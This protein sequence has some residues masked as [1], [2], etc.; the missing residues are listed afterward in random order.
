MKT[1][2]DATMQSLD[3]AISLVGGQVPLAESLGVRQQTVSYWRKAG[4]PVEHCAAIERLAG[5]RV[6]R[7]DLRPE[8]WAR[9]WPELAA[10]TGQPCI[11]VAHATKET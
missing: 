2:R 11:D 8:D 5:G 1:E 7:R 9:I 10:P 3:L 6:T 4:V